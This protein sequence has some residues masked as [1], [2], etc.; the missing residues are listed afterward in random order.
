M[1]VKEAIG[2]AGGYPRWMLKTNISRA[3]DGKLHSLGSVLQVGDSE[4]ENQLHVADGF[5]NDTLAEDEIM[6]P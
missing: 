6:V 4:L 1:P 2:V 5:P 3:V